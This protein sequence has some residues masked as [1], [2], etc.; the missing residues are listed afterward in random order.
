[1][2]KEPLTDNTGLAD[3]ALPQSSSL[4]SGLTC[5]TV[6]PDFRSQPAPMCGSDKG[7]PSNVWQGP[8]IIHNR[9]IWTSQK[10]LD[11]VARAWLGRGSINKPM[12]QFLCP[13]SPSVCQVFDFQPDHHPP[14]DLLACLRGHPTDGKSCSLIHPPRLALGDS[15]GKNTGV[16]CHVL[17]QEIFSAWGSNL[18]L[19]HCK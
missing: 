11:F 5:G 7:N 2:A 10:K 14:P 17:L 8:K 15:P 6:C 19:L 18:G 16:G 9:R 12:P 3:S 13:E 4:S 1:M